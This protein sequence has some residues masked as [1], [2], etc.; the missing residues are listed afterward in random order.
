VW[1]GTKQFDQKDRRKLNKNNGEKGGKR[2]PGS[3]WQ[4]KK[5]SITGGRGGGGRP[6]QTGKTKEEGTILPPGLSTNNKASIRVWKGSKG[7]RA[8][9]S[10]PKGEGVRDAELARTE[11]LKRWS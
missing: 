5:K 2:N 7:F 6:D 9:G 4:K 8:V 1:G 11:C 3:R 10:T